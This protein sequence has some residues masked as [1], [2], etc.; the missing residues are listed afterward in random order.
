MLD[1]LTRARAQAMRRNELPPQEQ[2][3]PLQSRLE[4]LAQQFDERMRALPAQRFGYVPARPR[5]S[6]LLTSVFMHGGWLHL[7][8][9][10]LFFFLSGP[11]IEDAYGRTIFACFY[12]MAG[13][14]AALSHALANAGSAAALVGASGA[15][16][17]VMGAFLIRYGKRRISFL[18]LPIPVLPMIRT[19][20]FMPAYVVLP[21]WFGQQLLFAHADFDATDIAWWAHIGGFAFGC[22]TA[23][24][25]RATRVEERFIS[26][27][28][29]RKISFEAHPSL[30]R[31]IDARVA[32][33]LDEAQGELDR[34]I[35][36]QPGNTDVWMEA[37]ELGLARNDTNALGRAAVRLL[38][39]CQRAGERELA[40]Q[41][42]NDAR[43]R[44]VRPV[45][46]QLC[47][48]A[49]ALF[50][51]EGDARQALELYEDVV[52]SSP[53][54]PRALRALV[55]RGELLLAGGDMRAA[56]L[57][58]EAAQRHPAYGSL[59]SKAVEGGLQAIQSASRPG[60]AQAPGDERE[61]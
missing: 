16:A 59:W 4:D 28:I 55:R 31:I 38:D 50:E 33:R 45:S 25:L 6:S 18:F 30:E 41:I 60:G 10:M 2:L 13:A 24:L 42:A 44:E 20:F 17:G 48:A 47:F 35:A 5:A 43:W 56:R 53:A 34:L 12:L 29:E 14:V 52:L 19:T 61:S 54:D 46:P 37:Y 9:N 39:L 51:Q 22:V 21:F 49:G 15:I 36:S 57:A 40:L 58:F 26:P 8:G 27:A 11:F 32:G 7:L 1:A 3:R 23:L